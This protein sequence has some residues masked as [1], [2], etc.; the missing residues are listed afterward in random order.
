MNVK[1][2]KELLDICERSELRDHAFGDREIF[3]EFDGVDVAGG[4]F[5]SGG[6]SVLIYDYAVS[7]GNQYAPIQIAS[8][9]DDEAYELVN[10]GKLAKIDRN[11]MQGDDIPDY[12]GA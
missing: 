11:D 9:E 3:W 2:A 5:G 1:E 12:R 10:C 4:Y 7:K 6:K 8:F